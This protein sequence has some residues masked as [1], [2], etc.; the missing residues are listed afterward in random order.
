MACPSDLS[1]LWSFDP[2]HEPTPIA[3]GSGP[4]GAAAPRHWVAAPR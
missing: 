3:A 1:T 4:V 2:R